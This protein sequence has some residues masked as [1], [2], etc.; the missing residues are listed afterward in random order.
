MRRI[1][2]K[3]VIA[4]FIFIG[5]STCLL[6]WM[7]WGFNRSNHIVRNE[8]R[9]NVIPFKTILHFLSTAG[10][11]N[12]INP[13]INIL[14]NIGVFIPLGFLIPVLFKRLTDYKWFSFVFVGSLILLEILQMMLH[15]G[16]ADIDDVILNFVG[17]TLG[18]LLFRHAA[19]YLLREVKPWLH[20]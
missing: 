7:F 16:T 12:L 11:H 19:G 8:L 2:L 3:K 1:N 5:Y 4:W 18:L 15:V 20:G 9:Y 14:G 6:Y 17:G 13:A 10:W